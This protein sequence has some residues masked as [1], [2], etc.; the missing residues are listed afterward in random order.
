MNYKFDKKISVTVRFPKFEA[1]YAGYAPKE[2]GFP[3]AIARISGLYGN[4]YDKNKVKKYWYLVNRYSGKVIKELNSK[5]L[6]EEFFNV[7]AKHIDLDSLDFM[8]PLSDYNY[9]PARI[10]ALI[11]INNKKY[12][13]INFK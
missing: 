11:E 2:P 7:F 13:E 12:R 8:N 9:S 5:R 4:L 3:F 1:T 10:S 6:I